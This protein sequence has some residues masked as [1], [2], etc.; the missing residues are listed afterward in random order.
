MKRTIACLLIPLAALVAQARL[1]R[2]WTYQELFDQSDLVVVARP[3]SIQDNLEQAVLANIK[4]DVF[5]VGVA[6]E[7]EVSA[8]LKGEKDTKT[9]TLHHYRLAEPRRPMFNGPNLVSFDP[10]QPTRFLLFLH[11]EPDGRYAPVSGQTDP[12]LFSVL[13]LDG[14]AR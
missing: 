8:V 9:V 7:F 12:A 4:P 14:A 10:K 11:C 3:I 6:T 1:M 5:V 2:A 13:K